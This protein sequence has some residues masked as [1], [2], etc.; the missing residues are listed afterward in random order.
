MILKEVTEDGSG[1]LEA[2]KAKCAVELKSPKA[3]WI[4]HITK[5]D[6]STIRDCKTQQDCKLRVPAG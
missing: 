4:S 2:R 1:P 5:A 3:A 6:Q